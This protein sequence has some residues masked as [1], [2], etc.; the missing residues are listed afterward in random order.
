MSCHIASTGLLLSCQGDD[1]TYLKI[2]PRI[3]RGLG[4]HQV[5]EARG[6]LPLVTWFALPKS[7]LYCRGNLTCQDHVVG[8]DSIALLTFWGLVVTSILSF[9]L[10]RNWLDSCYIKKDLS[11]CMS[12]PL[13]VLKITDISSLSHEGKLRLATVNRRTDRGHNEYWRRRWV[14]LEE[15]PRRESEKK[16]EVTEGAITPILKDKT[17]L[18]VMRLSCS[19]VALPTWHL[20]RCPLPCYHQPSS[21]STSILAAKVLSSN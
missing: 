19:A 13:S 6:L 2:S 10:S 20:I 1:V 12:T 11:V 16:G 4:H 3:Q 17:H 7:L 18:T 15:L 9:N 21:S 14:I 5:Q 8:A